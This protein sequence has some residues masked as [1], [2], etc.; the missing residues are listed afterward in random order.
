MDS[1]VPQKKLSGKVSKNLFVWIFLQATK[2]RMSWTGI[3]L[4]LHT[5]PFLYLPSVRASRR[6]SKA[7]EGEKRKH[8]GR[9][10]V[11]LR[12]GLATPNG[13]NL[14]VQKTMTAA[15]W[16]SGKNWAFTVS[17]FI[18]SYLQCCCHFLI[19]AEAFVQTQFQK[20]CDA[21]QNINKKECVNFLNPFWHVFMPASFF[22]TFFL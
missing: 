9:L 16:N 21:V 15:V 13:R 5:H 2:L 18:I 4:C 11:H 7:V 12:L 3:S 14:L 22:L 19:S 17:L 1:L 10:P 20:S 6:C 8:P